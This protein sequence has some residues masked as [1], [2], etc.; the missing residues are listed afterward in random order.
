MLTRRTI[1]QA[2]LATVLVAGLAG[3]SEIGHLYR[4]WMAEYGPGWKPMRWPFPRDAWPDG[5]AWRN[6]GIEVYVRLK[7]GLCGNCETGVVED[8]EVDKV[9]DIDFLDPNFQP[10]EAGRRAR[11]TDLFGRSRLYRL[12]TKDGVQRFAE[13]IVVSYKC[14]LMIATVVGDLADEAKRKE[15][16][17]FLE[18]NTVQVWVNQQLDGR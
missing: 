7:M 14:D 13:G 10:V 9:A 18:S 3:F 6:Q 8:A 16:R 1:V 2:S 5:R 4:A 11:I 15:A 17:L 12:T